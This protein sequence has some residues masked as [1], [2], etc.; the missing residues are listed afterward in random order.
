MKTRIITRLKLAFTL[1][2]LLVVIAIVGILVGILIPAVQMVRE[3][4]RRTDCSNKVRQIALGLLNF[5]SVHGHL[6]AG[7]TAYDAQPF[8][9]RSWLQEVL[10]FA[11]LQPLFDRAAQDYQSS[12]SP[13]S[14]HLGMQT[15]VDLYQCPSEA[16]SGQQHWTHENRLV[17]S[18]S[19]L[20]VNGTDWEKRDGVF[21]RDSRTGF[22]E[23]ADGTTHTLMI[24]ERPA[25]PDF[26]YGWWYAGYGQQ[27]TGSCDMLLGVRERKAPPTPG[28]TNWLESCP[29]GP[30]EFVPGRYGQRCDTLHFWSY[31]PG[32]AVFAMCDGSTRL[33]GYSAN[34]IMP[35]LATRDGGEM[36]SLP[37]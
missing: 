24:G 7:I 20:G 29:D 16:D 4:A 27:G 21:Y 15:V 11:E 23:I 12:P 18:T 3:G 28:V 10:P 8:R 33:I 32:G 2:E 14:G 9:S 22:N 37:K 1:V 13:F 36:V 34:E 17:A 26:W 5:E 19:Y 25:S 31:H 35:Q 6:P 30:Y